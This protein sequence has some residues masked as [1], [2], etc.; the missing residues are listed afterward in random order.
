M[1]IKRL[2]IVP[3]SVGVETICLV[4]YATVRFSLVLTACFLVRINDPCDKFISAYIRYY[5]HKYYHNLHISLVYI[6]VG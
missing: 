2:N 1:K 5:F 3:M 6:K 4:I